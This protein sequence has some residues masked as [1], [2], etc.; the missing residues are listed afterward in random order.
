M[1]ISNER[2]RENV[3]ARRLSLGWTQSKAADRLGVSQPQ[4]AYIESGRNI[5]T[6]AMVD[7][8]AAAL[9]TT[10]EKLITNK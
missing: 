2:F 5:P 1:S 10:P 7:R 4:W 3:R 8:V 9:N 6:L